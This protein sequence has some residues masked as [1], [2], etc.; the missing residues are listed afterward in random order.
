MCA[1]MRG[2]SRYAGVQK[3][4]QIQICGCSLG[5]G[6]AVLETGKFSVAA[7]VASVGDEAGGFG[8]LA[9]GLSTGGAASPLANTE[10][11]ARQAAIFSVLCESMTNFF[12][13][14]SLKV[15]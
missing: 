2:A 14:P 4:A 1:I 6:E 3:P 13:E 9:L 15:L 5:S 11:H 8:S 7:V 12:G 10:G